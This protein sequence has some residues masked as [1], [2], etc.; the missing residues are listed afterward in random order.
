MFRFLTIIIAIF[1]IHSSWPFIEKQFDNTSL[2]NSISEVKTLKDNPEVKT[3][4]QTIYTEI[5]TAL[6]QLGVLLDD[7][8]KQKQQST[9]SNNESKV[10]LNTPAQQD[11]SIFNIELGDSKDDVIEN[12]G[13]PNRSTFNEYGTTW[14]TYHDNYQ[15]FF[16]VMYDNEDKVA[17][18][19]SNQ[20]LIASKKGIKLGTAKETVRNLLGNPLTSIQKGLVLYKLPEQE[21]YDIFLRDNTYVTV[22]YDKH[23]GNTVTAVQLISKDL[24]NKKVD[25]YTKP[26]SQL[27]EGFEYQLF[28]LTNA[29]RVEHQLPILTWD[30]HVQG[31]ARKHS[32]DMAVN[33]YFDHTNLK[34]QSPF[35]RMAADDIVYQLAGENLA[36]GQFSSIFAHEGLMNSLGHRENILRKGYT[37]LGVGVAFNNE[38]QPYYTE[39]FYA[40]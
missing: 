26:S 7:S 5:Q 29:A 38:S 3:T 31:T 21:D 12:L 1:L 39:N 34:G 40:K 8:T 4:I 28:D 35:D 27:K 37:Y 30:E 32:S 10:E 20:D 9:G 2:S 33:N 11:F 14:N 15:N 6:K 13:T 24:E 19:Y 16:M 18:L 25:F 22:F 17:G 23:E 36:Y